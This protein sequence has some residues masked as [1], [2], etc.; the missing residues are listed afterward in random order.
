MPLAENNDVVE[1]VPS[2]RTNEPFRVSVLPGRADRG[3]SVSY[4]HRPT[5][6]NKSLTVGRIPVANEIFRCFPPTVGFGQ[7]LCD[8]LSIRMRRHAQPHQLAASML[9]DQKPV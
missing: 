6:P 1:T 3:G 7:L 5:A 2:D 4:T 8:P 9:Q